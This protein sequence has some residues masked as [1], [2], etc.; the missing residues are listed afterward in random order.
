MGLF[1]PHPSQPD[2]KEL[3]L[4][5]QLQQ[6]AAPYEA[7]IM[8]A[9]Q[10][11]ARWA[12]PECQLAR[13][14]DAAAGYQW[15]LWHTREDGTQFVDLTVEVYF[16]DRSPDQPRMFMVAFKTP[17]GASHTVDCPLHREDLMYAL[18]RAVASH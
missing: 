6:A 5:S 11:V 13:V 17:G 15:Q 18:R 10:W 9:L 12:L 4:R 14:E 3:R 1:H 7:V 8:A 2:D 16:L